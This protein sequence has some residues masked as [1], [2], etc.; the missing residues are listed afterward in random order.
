[1]L[2]LQKVQEHNQKILRKFNSE[3][4]SNIE[5]VDHVS[6]FTNSIIGVLEGLIESIESEKNSKLREF[7]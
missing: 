1:M 6:F 3:N 4:G 7:E 5:L 2:T